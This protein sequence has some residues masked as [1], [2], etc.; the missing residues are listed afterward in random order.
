MKRHF[1]RPARRLLAAAESTLLAREFFTLALVLLVATAV[2][3]FIA[4]ADAVVEGGTRAVDTALL[5]A[6]RSPTDQADPLGPK[7]LEELFRNFSALGSVAVLLFISLSIAGFLALQRKSHELL[8][9]AVAVSGGLLL[10]NALKVGF[11]RPR[12]DLV[13]HGDYVT[14]ASFPSGHSMLATVTYL[15]LGALL[16]RITP[17]RRTKLYVLVVA[18]A[19]SFLIGLSRVYL[20]V[21]WPSDVVAGWMAG[22]A[23]AL[24][25]WLVAR[26]LQRR[27][28]LGQGRREPRL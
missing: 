1:T 3:G 9:L 6:L 26:W 10:G 20:G 14:T 18:I 28:R 25:W 13:P 19:L 17:D 22:A 5:L 2:W 4:L 8:L 7:W 27:R 12:P 24:L 21:H 11:D 23:W 16:A 15:T